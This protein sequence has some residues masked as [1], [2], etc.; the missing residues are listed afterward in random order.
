MISIEKK[1]SSRFG[2]INT[3]VLVNSGF[4]LER[5]RERERER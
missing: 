2:L 3:Q 1:Y 5:E 4:L